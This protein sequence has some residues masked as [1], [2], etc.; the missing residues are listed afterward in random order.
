MAPAV[1][2]S[3]GATNMSSDEKAQA[4][5]AL[6]DRGMNNNPSDTGRKMRVCI[7]RLAF[8]LLPYTMMDLIV[9]PEIKEG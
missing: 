4:R 2:L 9:S 7:L 6:S 1:I 5:R 8:S 3:R